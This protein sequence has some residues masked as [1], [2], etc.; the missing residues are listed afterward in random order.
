MKSRYWAVLL[1]VLL[2]GCAAFSLPFLLPSSPAARAEIKSDGQVIRIVP[3]SVDQEFTVDFPGGG[4]NTVTVKDGKIAVTH[5][6]CPDG[7]CMER[8]FCDAGTPIGCLPHKLVI[9]FLGENEIDG[10]VG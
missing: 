8:G 2:I 7:Y 1:G 5:A 6:D 4:T 10:A 3:L 9:T